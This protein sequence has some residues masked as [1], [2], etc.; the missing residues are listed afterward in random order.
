MNLK[1]I[2]SFY[3]KKDTLF[4][5]IKLDIQKTNLLSSNGNF[6]IEIGVN[7]YITGIKPHFDKSNLDVENTKTH[8]PN[9]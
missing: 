6:P 3:M 2:Y 1:W 4:P 8:L 9:C 7:L 5:F